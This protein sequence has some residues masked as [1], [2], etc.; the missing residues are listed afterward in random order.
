MDSVDKLRERQAR[1]D[2]IIAEAKTE[3]ANLEIQVLEQ[4]KGLTLE[5]TTPK[6]ATK[7]APVKKTTVAPKEAPAKTEAPKAEPKKRR[8]MS[9]KLS[10]KKMFTT[11]E[12]KKMLALLEE[13]ENIYEDY[14]KFDALG[15]L[16]FAEFLE[17]KEMIEGAEA[18]KTMDS[19]GKK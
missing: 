10:L 5:T 4:L 19:I 13:F 2:V 11:M 3:R 12:D 1:C 17:E 16:A 14:E 18:L 9:Y 8:H 15:K 6:N 7:E